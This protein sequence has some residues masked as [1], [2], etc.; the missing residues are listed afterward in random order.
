MKFDVIIARSDIANDICINNVKQISMTSGR[1]IIATSESQEIIM[2]GL[3]D[4]MH[5]IRDMEEGVKHE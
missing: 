3:I 5:V 4:S 1:T 2:T